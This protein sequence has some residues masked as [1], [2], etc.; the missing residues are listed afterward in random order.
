M[1]VPPVEEQVQQLQS[2]IDRLWYIAQ[3]E[4]GVEMADLDRAPMY[5]SKSV[6]KHLAMVGSNN[7]MNRREGTVKPF[8]MTITVGDIHE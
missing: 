1:T 2:P 3:L 7:P 5:G 8:S 6:L 4:R